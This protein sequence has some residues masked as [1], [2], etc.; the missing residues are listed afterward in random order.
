MIDWQKDA[1]L[2]MLYLSV[3]GWKQCAEHNSEANVD[4]IKNCCA[5]LIRMATQKTAGQ[6]P[7][8]KKDDI[9]INTLDV[10]TMQI[11]LHATALCLD[12]YFGEM[13]ERL[14]A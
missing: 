3:L 8:A 10:L 1:K 13:P 7:Y 5:R 6:K 9:D 12:G 11:A 4:G 2:N 14:E